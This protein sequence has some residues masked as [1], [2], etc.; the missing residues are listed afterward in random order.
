[1]RR[2]G[3]R[4]WLK[5]G[6]E[7]EGAWDKSYHDIAAKFKGAKGKEDG[8]VRNLVGNKGEITTRPHTVLDHLI[9]DVLGMYPDRV[10]DTCGFHIHTSFEPL[11]YSTLAD[12]PFWDFYRKR[13]KAFGE[14]HQDAMD[15]T[16]RAEFWDR[17]HGRGPKATRYC[18]AEFKPEEQFRDHNDRY[19]QLNFV[20]YHKYQTLESRLLPMFASKDIAVLAIREMSDIYDTYLNETDF[21]VISHYSEFRQEGDMAVEERKFKLPDYS[22]WAEDHREKDHAPLPKGDDVFY[23]IQGATEYMLPWNNR[24]TEE[25]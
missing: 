5:M 25:P 9:E 22:A 3:T 16:S 19:T 6:I 21:P 20:A 15:P 2:P 12:K 18:K 8:S 1:M 23:N 11:D 4:R 10:N 14:Q 7:L 24:T 17:W 13:W